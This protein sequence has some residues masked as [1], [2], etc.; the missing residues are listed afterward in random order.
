MTQHQRDLIEALVDDAYEDAVPRCAHCGVRTYLYR[1]LC[2]TCRLI[3]Y[4]RRGIVPPTN[5][6]VRARRG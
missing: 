1:G 4:L 5:N 3:R 6:V 2:R